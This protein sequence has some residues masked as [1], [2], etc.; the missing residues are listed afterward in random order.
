MSISLEELKKVSYLKIDK[1]DDRAIPMQFV[2]TQMVNGNRGLM[3][4][5]L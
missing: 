3:Q 2:I 4:V 5:A 1:V